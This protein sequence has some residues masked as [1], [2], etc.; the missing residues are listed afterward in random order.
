MQEKI[1]VPSEAGSVCCFYDKIPSSS[2]VV[3]ISHGYTSSKSSRTAIALSE[4]LNDAG[5]STIRPDLYGHGESEGDITYLT[6]E[7]AVKN[8]VAVYDYV[9][10]GYKKIALV[11]SSFSW[12]VSLITAT[13]RPLATLVLKCPVFEYKKLFDDRLAKEGIEKWKKEK[14]IETFGKKVSF[15]AYENASGYDMKKIASAI[16]IPVLVIHGDRDTTVPIAQ[17]ESLISLLKSEKEFVIIKGADH[18]FYG[19]NHFNKMI[20]TSFVWLINHLK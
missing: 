6:I 7:K 15:E 1:F 4:R 3:I 20:E 9:K 18:F 17:P 14:F 10:S 2:S 16:K 19:A 8:L 12:M 13:K 11:G 5:I